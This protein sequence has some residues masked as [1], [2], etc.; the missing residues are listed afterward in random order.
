[1]KHVPTIARYL[2]GLI[3]FVFGLNKFLQ[4]LPQPELSEAPMAFFGA[5]MATGYMFPFIAV[6][7]ILAGALLL[8]NRFVPV[9][10]VVV[11]PV[12]LHILLFHIFL[13]SSG[14]VMGIAVFALNL[15]LLFAY[16]KY[17]YPFLVASATPDKDSE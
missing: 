4:F 9:A 1:M 15:Y 12:T 3:F 8:A 13:D 10:L 17:Y 5:L 14:L 6:V 16:K 7:E 2:F 11:A